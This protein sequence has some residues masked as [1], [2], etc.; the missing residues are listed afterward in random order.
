MPSVTLK[1]V[2]IC[3]YKIKLNLFLPPPHSPNLTESLGER[4]RRTSI[5]HSVRY[6]PHPWDLFQV[7]G[8]DSQPT[9]GSA[10]SGTRRDSILRN[11]L[12][13]LIGSCKNWVC[14]DPSGVAAL[15]CGCQVWREGEEREGQRW[16]VVTWQPKTYRGFKGLFQ[17]DGMSPLAIEVCIHYK[18][19]T[20]ISFTH[21][22]SFSLTGCYDSYAV[23]LCWW[24]ARAYRKK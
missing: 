12:T 17:R 18:S 14:A 15:R 3:I 19:D 13:D 24:Y 6:R 4:S 16:C 7:V 22:L 8:W 1:I 10:V 11:T 20:G 2:F 21:Y 5:H 23:E 9:A